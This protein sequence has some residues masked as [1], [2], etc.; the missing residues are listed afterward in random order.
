MMRLLNYLCTFLLAQRALCDESIFMHVGDCTSG[1]EINLGVAGSPAECQTLCQS[2]LPYGSGCKYFTLAASGSGACFW[3]ESCTSHNDAAVWKGYRVASA[4]V[5]P[6][7]MHVGDCTSGTEV[8]LGEVDT[9]FECQT[10]CLNKYGANCQYVTFAA[11]ASKNG[12]CFWEPS[13]TAHND[14]AVWKGN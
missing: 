7:F 6:V 9:L 14:N 1:I 5:E 11:V 4:T 12:A 8:K 3:E 13:C 10:L 2:F